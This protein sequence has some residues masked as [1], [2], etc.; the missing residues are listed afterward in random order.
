MNRST[1]YLLL[2]L[3][4]LCSIPFFAQSD[5][6]TGTIIE[7]VDL[8]AL[9]KSSKQT[10]RPILLLMSTEYCPFCKTIKREILNPMVLSGDYDN[11]IIMRELMIDS[12]MEARN[13]DGHMQD[14][15]FI[16]TDY[17]ITVT[18]TMLFL[19][20]DG[21]ELTKRM[22]GINTPELFS[23]YVDQTINKAVLKLR[24]LKGE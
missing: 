2:I 18:P 24:G 19:G 16:A 15:S 6:S 7:T 10:K 4:S 13:F 8:A 22:V 21:K 3:I 1:Y 11:R 14:P 17:A 9:G 12:S 23:Y 5:T 20:P